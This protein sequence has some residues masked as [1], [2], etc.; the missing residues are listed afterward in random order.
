M[1]RFTSNV[2]HNIYLDDILLA[3]PVGIDEPT[4]A[5]IELDIFSNPVL[6]KL[7]LHLKVHESKK[8]KIMLVDALGKNQ[9]VLFSGELS[10][11]SAEPLIFLPSLPSGFYFLKLEW[12]ET[13][14]T[15]AGIICRK[16]LLL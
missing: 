16:L 6:E 5:P 13:S 7:T 9:A 15:P 12:Q 10:A 4:N 8:I 2:G 1:F 11:T 14:L 3:P